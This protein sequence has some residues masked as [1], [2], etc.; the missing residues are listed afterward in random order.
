M[1]SLLVLDSFGLLSKASWHWY[2]NGVRILVLHLV[3]KVLA[4][5]LQNA[6]GDFL[7]LDL[8][9]LSF[10]EAACTR[11]RH[12]NSCMFSGYDT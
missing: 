5:P 4:N 7:K 8:S 12:L 6:G 11:A 2:A 1:V 9:M 10:S 3:V